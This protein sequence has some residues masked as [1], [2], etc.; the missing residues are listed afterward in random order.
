MTGNAWIGLAALALACSGENFASSNGS[1]ARKD[2]GAFDARSPAGGGASSK[3]GRNGS[4]GSSGSSGDTGAGGNTSGDGGASTSGGL[5]GSGGTGAGGGAGG[6]S[7]T[8][9]IN[10]AGGNTQTGGG[11]GV[12]GAGTGGSGK[13]CGPGGVFPTFVKACGMTSNC[14][15]VQHETSCCGSMLVMAINHG[16]VTKFSDA[17]KICESQYPLCGCTATGVQAEDGTTV[18]TDKASAIIAECVNSTCRSRYGGKTFSCGPKTCTDL[19]YCSVTTGG[20]AGSLPTYNCVSMGNCSSCSC[21]PI[22]GACTCVPGTI[23]NT[24]TCNAP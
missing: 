6:A 10:N 22:S 15:L 21:L 9:G 19:E 20:P 24:V 4:S 8:G 12:A 13:L 1:N 7:A 17:E 23:G 2:G 3:G 16:E 11:T 5:T 18:P 14:A